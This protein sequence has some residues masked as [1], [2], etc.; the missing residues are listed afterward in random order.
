[1]CS[2]GQIDFALKYVEAILSTDFTN[3]LYE[4]KVFKE[5]V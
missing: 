5:T 3:N 2:I 1:M 4:G